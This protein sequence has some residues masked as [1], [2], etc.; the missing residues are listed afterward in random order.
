MR[1][2]YEDRAGAIE[3]VEMDI[4]EPCPIC[5]GKLF[6][7]DE[8]DTESGFRCSSCNIRFAPSTDDV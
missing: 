8:S 3:Q 1:V 5:C 4:E 2:Q 7:I 6:L